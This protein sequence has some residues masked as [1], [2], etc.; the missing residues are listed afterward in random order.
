MVFG[1]VVRYGAGYPKA[2]DEAENESEPF[3]NAP[4]ALFRVPCSLFPAPSIHNCDNLKK[5]TV[6][7]HS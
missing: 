6:T 7:I 1:P 5:L 2:D 3:P 4:Y